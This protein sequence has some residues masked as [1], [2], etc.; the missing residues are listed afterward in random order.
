[1]RWTVLSCRCPKSRS[2]VSR[3]RR[4]L[5]RRLQRYARRALLSLCC[6]L[7]LLAPN[8]AVAQAVTSARYV[9]PTD[10]YPHGALG[11][12]LEWGA[13]EVTV[14]RPKAGQGG[15]HVSRAYRI[16]APA[17]S[18]FEDTKPRLWD[19]D[20]DGHSE[21]VV[22]ISH[23][24]LGAQLAVIVYEGDTFRYIAKTPPIGTR[25]RWLAPVGAA[26]LD[27]DGHVEIA[28]VL[29]PHLSKTLEIWRYKDG[30]FRR[31]A[32][33]RGL[34]NHQIGWDHIPGGLRNCDGTPELVTANADWTRVVAITFEGGAI[35]MREIGKYTRPSDLNAALECH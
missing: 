27:G 29:M 26:D 14:S 24:D 1:M 19:I 25:F 12:D 20:G 16:Q 10:V 30:N 7:P 5:L 3:A 6:W 13:V 4:L 28:F 11:D 2:D 15:G 31:M 35:G 22:V 9:S 8:Y 23:Q 32:Q 34:T 33:R 21:I 18:V 17:K